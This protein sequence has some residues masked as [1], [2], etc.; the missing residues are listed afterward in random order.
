MFNNW[1]ICIWCYFA[2]SN[3][4]FLS[5]SAPVAITGPMCSAPASGSEVVKY[6]VSNSE[7]IIPSHN[8]KDIIQQYQTP[9]PEPEAQIKRCVT[10]VYYMC[11]CFIHQMILFPFLLTPMACVWWQ[12]RRK[13]FCEEDEPTWWGNADPKNKE[14]QSTSSTGMSTSITYVL[15]N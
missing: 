10:C 8:I 12:A 11:L 7:H 2:F 4:F 13:S 14:G 5:L 6:S 15:N 9:S 1:N 3:P